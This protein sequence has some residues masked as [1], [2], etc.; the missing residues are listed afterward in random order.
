MSPGES[1]TL[2]WEWD[3]DEY[4]TFWFEAELQEEDDENSTNNVS[5]AMMRSVDIEFSDNMEDGR[6]GWSD[7]KAIANAWHL[8]DIEEDDKREAESGTHAMWAGDESKND[9]E[10]DD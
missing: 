10:Y 8:I 6:D 2:G 3:T 4:G 1:I 5:S 9:G 7:Y